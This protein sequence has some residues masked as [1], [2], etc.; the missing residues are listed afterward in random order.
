[1]DLLDRLRLDVS[2]GQPGWAAGWLALADGRPVL[3]AGGIAT[4]EDTRAAW[5]PGQAG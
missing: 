1:V 4:G 5:L 2:V 3:L